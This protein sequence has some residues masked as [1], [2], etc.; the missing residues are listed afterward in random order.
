LIS[1]LLLRFP[2][3]IQDLS[4]PIPYLKLIITTIL[5]ETKEIEANIK[6]IDFANS[7]ILLE[8]CN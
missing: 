4:H 2:G 7:N 8:I 6:G 3:N 5:K 1:L